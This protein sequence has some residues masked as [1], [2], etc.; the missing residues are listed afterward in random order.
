[1]VLK[2]ILASGLLCFILIGVAGCTTNQLVDMQIKRD[3]ATKALS[4]VIARQLS[5]VPLPAPRTDWRPGLVFGVDNG[6]IYVIESP[7][8][9]PVNIVPRRPGMIHLPA[10][11][12]LASSDSRFDTSF[13]LTNIPI[14]FAS[15][16]TNSGVTTFSIHADALTT[17]Y[18]SL[19]DVK[20]FLT[21]GNAPNTLIKKLDKQRFVVLEVVSTKK[22]TYEFAS[23]NSEDAGLRAKIAKLLLDFDAGGEISQSVLQ[24][25]SIEEQQEFTL[26]YKALSI[27]KIKTM[28][29]SD[30]IIVR[31]ITDEESNTLFQATEI[32]SE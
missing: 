32:Q 15:A 1:M 8:I 31:D 4:T 16:L 7:D 22:L 29:Q 26:G 13:S 3:S 28:G 2:T 27:Y 21:N 25:G 5:Y 19:G 18:I 6:L 20:R 14:S 12:Y 24:H 30:R 17:E 10:A 9:F 23:S 11:T